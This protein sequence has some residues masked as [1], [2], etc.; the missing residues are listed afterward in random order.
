YLAVAGLEA[1]LRRWQLIALETAGQGSLFDLRLKVFRHL[2]RLP[3]RFFDRTPIGRLVG[4][5]TTDIEALQ[6]VFSSGLVT[7]L[8]DFVF[9][10]G[11]LGGAKRTSILGRWMSPCSQKRKFV[12][13]LA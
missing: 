6:E 8:G 7:I 5:V 11:T 4:R 13:S 1:L 3:A 10:I 12:L 2:Q 9:L